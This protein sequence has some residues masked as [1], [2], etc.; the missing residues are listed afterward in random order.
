MATSAYDLV[1]ADDGQT[2]WVFGSSKGVG[3]IASVSVSE[4]G[5]GPPIGTGLRCRPD[6]LEAVKADAGRS[7]VRLGMRQDPDNQEVRTIDLGVSDDVI[8]IGFV[9][10]SGHILVGTAVSLASEKRDR[11]A[12]LELDRDHRLSLRCSE[13]E[14]RGAGTAHVW[15]R[16]VFDHEEDSVGVGL[17]GAGDVDDDGVEDLLLFGP[18]W[19]IPPSGIGG[20]IL[21]SGRDGATMS[22]LSN[23]KH[24]GF[25][26]CASMLSDRQVCVLDGAAAEGMILR[27]YAL[28]GGEWHYLMTRDCADVGLTKPLSMFRSGDGVFLVGLDDDDG[29][30]VAYMALTR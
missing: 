4:N 23:Q 22:V 18:N 28:R 14:D 10:S 15:N 13:R 5:V 12:W 29:L 27:V 2:A 21:I 19:G 3:D 17:R 24:S 16:P 11:V 1:E 8:D 30:Q 20:V 6:W 26:R 7:W 25:G 9:G